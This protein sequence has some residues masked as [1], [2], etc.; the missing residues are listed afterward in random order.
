MA[1]TISVHN[2]DQA[3]RGHNIRSVTAVVNQV[4]IEPRLTHL[5]ETLVDE[6]L[7]NAYKR[8]FG[9]A[10]EEYNDKQ[11]RSDRKIKNY[12]SKIIKENRTPVYETIIQVGNRYD[13]GIDAP[14]EKQILR[15]YVEGWKERNPNV[16]LIGAYI[17]ADEPD[18]TLHAHL[19]YI[20]VGSDYKRGMKIQS[21][22]DR[23]LNQQG[24]DG[25][26]RNP[27][28][29]LW[30]ASER[31]VLKEIAE[32]HGIEVKLVSGDK[33]KH[34]E[35]DEFIAMEKLKEVKTELKAVSER[36]EAQKK[37]LK[38]VEGKLLPVE[39]VNALKTQIKGFKGDKTLIAT[40]D[41]E[42]L[43]ATA[44]ISE[45]QKNQI[46][47]LKQE[48]NKLNI[49]L[50]ATKQ[51]NDERFKSM[52]MN[53]TNDKQGIALADYM[54]TEPSLKDEYGLSVKSFVKTCTNLTKA[55]MALDVRANKDYRVREFRDFLVES[56]GISTEDALN[57]FN[58]L[59]DDL[60]FK[61]KLELLKA[62]NLAEP[63]EEMMN[64][65]INDGF[66][67]DG[68]IASVLKAI[69]NQFEQEMKNEAFLKAQA[70]EKFQEKSKKK[71]NSKEI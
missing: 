52:T 1:T 41:Y 61:P 9:K 19:D 45:S 47:E 44:V 51:S 25:Y 43:K 22:L 69:G 3:N 33:L 57:G 11:T 42:K 31:E 32:S 23:A 38:V 55:K 56:P 34:M 17:H 35:K 24:F 67:F 27:A 14:V 13:T 68:G 16:E 36:L 37:D 7:A 58:E 48:I 2:G 40:E 4:H 65:I 26:K 8:I 21:S 60:N 15:E 64:E 63:N 18:G 29:K 12:L 30:T 39:G 50:L 49:N 5:N 10:V 53:K 46:S 54:R 28:I 66:G 20:G 70:V 59:V 62:Y 71:S 6:T